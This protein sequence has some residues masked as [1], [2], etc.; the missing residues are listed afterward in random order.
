M[1]GIFNSSTQDIAAKIMFDFV[2]LCPSEYEPFDAF[3][4]RR[5]K[6]RL[7][8]A[9]LITQVFAQDRAKQDKEWLKEIE[10]HSEFG[11]DRLPEFSEKVARVLRRFGS[12]RLHAQIRQMGVQNWPEMFFFLARIAQNIEEHN[13]SGL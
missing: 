6:E 11:G 4:K 9:Q 8:I 13:P 10:V 1:L 2:C 7:E 5:E 12:P 3:E